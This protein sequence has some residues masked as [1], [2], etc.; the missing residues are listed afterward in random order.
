MR[1]AAIARSASSSTASSIPRRGDTIDPE[2][3]AARLASARSWC[4]SARSTPSVE[5]HRVE[6]Q[7]I[8]ALEKAGRHVSIALEMFPFGEQP[9]LDAWAEGRWSEEEFLAKGRWYDVWGYRWSYYRDIF[10]HGRAGAHCRSWPRTCRAKSS[11]RCGRRGSSAIPP[12]AAD[13]LP[14]AI[15]VDS[16]EHLTFFKAALEDGGAH[17]GMPDDALKPMLAAQATWDAAMAWNAARALER[18][19]RTVGRGGAAGGIRA[20]CLRPRDR[21]PGASLVQGADCVGD[22]R[23]GGGRSRDDRRGARLVRE[24]RVGCRSRDVAG[25]AVVGYL[26]TGG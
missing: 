8:R 11:R 1:P 23:R 19:P 25:L 13:H 15:D 2:T 17:G 5:S 24:L 3:L 6:L 10:L 20:R 16:A 4:S 9:S 21:T 12:E 22:A 18:T 26:D 14:P 7:V